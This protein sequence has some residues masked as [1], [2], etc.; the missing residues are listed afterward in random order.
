MLS[1][2]DKGQEVVA[3]AT[4]SVLSKVRGIRNN[5]PGNLRAPNGYTGYVGDDGQGYAK[6]ESMPRGTRAAARQFKLNVQRGL[7]TPRKM[8]STWA[9]SNENDTAAYIAAYVKYTGQGENAVISLQDMTTSGQWFKGLRAI[10]RHECG[11]AAA[12]MFVS[13]AMI[14]E[15]MKTA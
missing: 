9:P 15:A 8:I 11:A 12:A 4:D 2:T 14:I 13:D 7:N 3:S 6:Y 1:K 5:N 10:F